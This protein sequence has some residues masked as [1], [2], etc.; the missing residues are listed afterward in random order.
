ML[1]F[2]LCVCL[3][4]C[5]SGFSSRNS[6]YGFRRYRRSF[7]CTYTRYTQRHK[8]VCTQA[9]LGAHTHGLLLYPFHMASHPLLIHCIFPPSSYPYLPVVVI[10]PC[11]CIP[12]PSRSHSLLTPPPLTPSS[13]HL[14]SLPPH[15]TSPHSLPQPEPPK[16][17]QQLSKR[18]LRKLNRMSVAH[19][20]QGVE[21]P[22]VVE[23]H[24]V[25]AQDPFLLV[26]LKVW[27]TLTHTHTH[28]WMNAHFT[29][30]FLSL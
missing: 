7:Q 11:C 22:E 14:P 4:V 9:P 8:Y 27:H 18:K 21:K 15:P 30:F 20:K 17:V 12:A 25:T 5:I 19:L 24:D 13:P 26:H 2:Q 1:P 16:E 29:H 3:F 28:K 23:M 6:K 10:V